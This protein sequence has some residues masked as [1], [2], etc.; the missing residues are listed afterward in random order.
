DRLARLRNRSRSRFSLR[1]HLFGAWILGTDCLYQTPPIH[2][3]VAANAHRL[4]YFPWFVL[5]KNC[6]SE[7]H[8]LTRY[9]PAGIV[10]GFEWRPCHGGISAPSGPGRWR[11]GYFE[12]EEGQGQTGIHQGLGTEPAQRRVAAVARA[13]TQRRLHGNGTAQA[14]AE[15][16][17]RAG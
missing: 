17:P 10:R 5:P 4:A 8:V 16:R 6:R 3:N 14:V 7:R 2:S 11:P 9:D 15:E 1:I 12:V 13:R